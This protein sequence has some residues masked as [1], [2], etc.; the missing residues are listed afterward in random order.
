M[1]NVEE[2]KSLLGALLYIA[3]KSRSDMSFTVNQSSRNCENP[4]E[5]D[6]KSFMHILQYLKRNN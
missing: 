5:A 3:V 6:Y 1:V 2:Y 4:T